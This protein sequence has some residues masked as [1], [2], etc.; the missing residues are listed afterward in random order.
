ML[1]AAVCTPEL[2]QIKEVWNMGVFGLGQWR[3]LDFTP[4]AQE[5]VRRACKTWVLDEIPRRCGKNIPNSLSE[6][7]LCVR[8]LSQ[9]LVR[10]RE[11]R[12]EN[13]AAL[14]RSDIEAFTHY[15]AQLK[16]TS[17][18]SSFRHTTVC[19]FTGRCCARSGTWA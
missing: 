2:E 5:W 11:D 17:E 10:S 15:V 9:S 1:A 4:L 7:I 18:I 8:F 3:W 16:H 14:G 13:M 19:R 6:M 12:G